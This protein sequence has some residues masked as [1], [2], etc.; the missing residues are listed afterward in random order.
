[1]TRGTMNETESTEDVLDIRARGDRLST[2]VR[3]RVSINGVA[4][5]VAIDPAE[6]IAWAMRLYLAAKESQTSWRPEF[7]SEGGA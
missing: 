6:A 4:R 7:N 3:V 2:R 1:M 5:V